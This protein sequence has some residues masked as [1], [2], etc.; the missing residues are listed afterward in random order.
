MRIIVVREHP[1]RPSEPAERVLGTDD[2][3]EALPLADFVMC[4]MPATDKTPRVCSM[5]HGSGR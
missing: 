2:L 5:K 4:A 1:D 3:D